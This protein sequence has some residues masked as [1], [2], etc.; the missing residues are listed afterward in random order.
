M[1]VTIKTKS[2]PT[3]QTIQCAGFEYPNEVGERW[4]ILTDKDDDEIYIFAADDVLWV[5]IEYECENTEESIP[6][7][8]EVIYHKTGTLNFGLGKPVAFP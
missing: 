2:N 8:K 7:D 4:F 1:K 6:A 3:E 5:S